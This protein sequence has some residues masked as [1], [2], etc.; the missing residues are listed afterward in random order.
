MDTVINVK[1][2]S[3]GSDNAQGDGSADD[4]AAI[5]KAA[6]ALQQ[7]CGGVLYFPKGVYRL[8]AA[9]AVDF[10]NAQNSLNAAILIRGSNITLQGD[11]VG[12]IIHQDGN[13]RGQDETPWTIPFCFY[14]GL[15]L[16]RLPNSGF[17]RPE[18]NTGNI[19]IKDL[20]FRGNISPAQ[21]PK[22]SDDASVGNG[23]GALLA[24]IGAP[25]APARNIRVVNCVFEDSNRTGAI[26]PKFVDDLTIENCVFRS[27]KDSI[28]GVRARAASSKNLNIDDNEFMNLAMGT[29][30]DFWAEDVVDSVRL[31]T[32]D[33]VL[34]P[35]Q[36]DPANNGV[37]LVDEEWNWRRTTDFRTEDVNGLFEQPI[38]IEEGLTNKYRIYQLRRTPPLTNPVTPKLFYEFLTVI[39]ASDQNYPYL[40]GVPPGD[41][42]QAAPITGSL[43][44][45]KDQTIL[46]ENGVYV[47]DRNGP[48]TKLPYTGNLLVRVREGGTNAGAYFR[49][50]AAPAFYPVAQDEVTGNP[51]GFMRVRVATQTPVPSIASISTNVINGVTLAKGDLVLLTGQTTPVRMA[52]TD[53][54][55]ARRLL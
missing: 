14:F 45:L 46:T 3:M 50:E 11:G 36:N 21:L 22:A 41:F 10:P 35:N 28:T 16:D 1:T 19:L 5:A 53:I 34:L 51:V 44:L 25:T 6:E 30:A 54:L 27:C 17:Q 52:C 2:W 4:T 32:G 31:Q 13:P 15:G 43:V 12:S 24:F 8:R 42:Q 39:A 33:R 55:Q 29:P 23:L 38:R 40:T 18:L 49:S 7:I 20:T 9:A 26:C 37:Y 47:L 48:W